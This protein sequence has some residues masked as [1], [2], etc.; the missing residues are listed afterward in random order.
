M[1]IC[2]VYA[3][4]HFPYQPNLFCIFPTLV[5]IVF[6]LCVYVFEDCML[7]WLAGQ[8]AGQI[9]KQKRPYP[10]CRSARRPFL[11]KNLAGWPGNQSNRTNQTNQ[12]NIKSYKTYAKSCK[13][14]RLGLSNDMSQTDKKPFSHMPT[15]RM[16]KELDSNTQ[17]IS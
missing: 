3:L 5:F 10:I 15:N 16:S 8:T 11:L 4:E 2:V 7:V 9:K 17:Q 12:T 13:N 1:C 14:Q 6:V